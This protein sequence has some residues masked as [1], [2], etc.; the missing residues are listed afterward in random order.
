[1]KRLS[2]LLCTLLLLVLV[3]PTAHADVIVSPVVTVA[4]FALSALPWI[5]IAAVVVITLLLLWKL[6]K[7][8]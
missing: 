1:M 6:W 2:A 4:V 5:L 7:K 3:S 8:K